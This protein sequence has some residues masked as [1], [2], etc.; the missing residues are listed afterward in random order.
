MHFSGTKWKDAT[1][2][3]PVVFK[4]AEK[5]RRL[6]LPDSTQMVFTPL[7]VTDDHLKIARTKPSIHL[8]VEGCN[9]DRNLSVVSS[10]NVPTPRIPA[11]VS[12]L[13]PING[14]Q[15]ALNHC[16]LFQ[17]DLL[18]DEVTSNPPH[19]NS[20]QILCLKILLRSLQRRSHRFWRSLSLQSVASFSIMQLMHRFLTVL[21]R[22]RFT[23]GLRIPG[24]FEARYLISLR[25]R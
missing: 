10:L 12:D 4:Q 7:N 8:V 13:M 15:L 25:G 18:R 24:R 9:V 16:H 19:T 6:P 1:W 14:N 17:P 11:H 23:K 2:I 21:Q 20:W 5:L 3:S 22:L